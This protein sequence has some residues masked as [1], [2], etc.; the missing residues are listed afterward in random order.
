MKQDLREALPKV[1]NPPSFTLRKEKQRR[2]R[3]TSPRYQWYLYL[4]MTNLLCHRSWANVHESQLDIE[5]L[6]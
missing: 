2:L 4:E 5:G 6:I 3:E 1:R